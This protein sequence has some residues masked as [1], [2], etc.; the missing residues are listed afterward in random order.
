MLPVALLHD[1]ILK[2]LLAP[3]DSSDADKK[4]L[5]YPHDLD[6]AVDAVVA[7]SSDAAFILEPVAVDKVLEHARQGKVMPQKSTFFYPKLP[8]G[9]VLYSMDLS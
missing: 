3:E 5:S 4:M 6:S 7:G 2:P 8:S 9:L 1:N